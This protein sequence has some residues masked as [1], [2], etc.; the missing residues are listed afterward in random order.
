MK[1]GLTLIELV[2][3]IAILAILIIIAVKAQTLKNCHLD[4]LRFGH[5]Q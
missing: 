3:V 2:I 5:Y 1:K 4:C